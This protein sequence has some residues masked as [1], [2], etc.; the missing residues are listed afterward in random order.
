MVADKVDVESKKSNE[1]ES[2]IW[3]SD[4]KNTYS[5]KKSNK[6]TKGTIIRLYIKKDSN[7]FLDSLRLNS[8]ITKY[9]NYIPFPI[10]LKDEDNKKEKQEKL[11]RENLYGLKIKKI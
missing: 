2:W 9:S 3:T 1:T 10:Y 8:I 7:E 11:M 5:I 6:N 4:G